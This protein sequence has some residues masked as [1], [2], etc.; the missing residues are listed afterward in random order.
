LFDRGH[1]T[2]FNDYRFTANFAVYSAP[3]QVSGQTLMKND[4]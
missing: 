2:L 3:I 1:F 4:A